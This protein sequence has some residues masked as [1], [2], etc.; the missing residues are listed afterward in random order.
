M[1]ST[2]CG[3]GRWFFERSRRD[4]PAWNLK[5]SY[6]LVAADSQQP[7][8]VYGPWFETDLHSLSSR[9]R[10]DQPIGT[11]R[12]CP[13]RT[14]SRQASTWWSATHGGRCTRCRPCRRCGMPPGPSRW[15]PSPGP[16]GRGWPTTSS[17]SAGTR[18]TP[19]TRCLRRQNNDVEKTR[20]KE[21]RRKQRMDGQKKGFIK[22]VYTPTRQKGLL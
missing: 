6:K 2:W 19:Q 15:R 3:F 11:F 16:A 10:W 4:L 22:N 14:G 13:P 9:P 18:R 20:R 12:R 5:K 21:Q 8:F 17:S 7:L 1:W